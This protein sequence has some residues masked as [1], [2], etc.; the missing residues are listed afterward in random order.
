MKQGAA[1]EGRP[2][3]CS[4]PRPILEGGPFS[5]PIRTVQRTI[6][7]GFRDVIGIN[8]FATLK[9]CNGPAHFENAIVSSRGESEPMHRILEHLFAVGIDLAV[10]TDHAR[11]HGR[12]RKD[13][14]A[15]KATML[16]LAC[17]NHALPNR[18]RAIRLR[19]SL[20]PQLTKLHGGDVNVDVDAVQQWSRD[21]TNVSLDLSYRAATLAHRV[22]EK[23]TRTRI[24]GCR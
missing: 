16:S 14:L 5:R 13:F 19:S 6:T 2:Y 21:A 4:R 18:S 20:A 24:H 22:I 9:V 1:T 17:L 10:R 7:Y 3:S 15:R 8:G 12:V 11:R 23:T